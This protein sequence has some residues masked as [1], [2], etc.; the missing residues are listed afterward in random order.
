MFR[1]N[2]STFCSN[3]K[4]TDKESDNA[5]F[6]SKFFLPDMCPSCG[7]YPDWQL[8]TEKQQYMPYKFPFSWFGYW[9]T[10]ETTSKDAP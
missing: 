6:L 1:R 4:K 10:V 9:V 8:K 7:E 5:E 2:H 3:C